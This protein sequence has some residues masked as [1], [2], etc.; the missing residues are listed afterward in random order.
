VSSSLHTRRSP[1]SP[2]AYHILTFL[3]FSPEYY[4]LLLLNSSP[5]YRIRML[6]K[7]PAMCV[8]STA[9]LTIHLNA[10]NHC[11]AAKTALKPYSTLLYSTLLSSTLLYSTLLYSTLLYSTLMARRDD[12]LPPDEAAIE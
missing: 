4:I 7:R 11:H 12:D 5:D 9:T 2:P 6:P 3:N 10:T 8:C 1:T